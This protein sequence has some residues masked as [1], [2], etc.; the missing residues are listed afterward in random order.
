M[1]GGT[2]AAVAI[3]AGYVLGRRR[4]MRLATILSLIHI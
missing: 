3:G 2:R 1:K 4:K